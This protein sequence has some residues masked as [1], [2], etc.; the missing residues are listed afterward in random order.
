M[1]I[2]TTATIRRICD[3]IDDLKKLDMELRVNN[4]RLFTESA[5]KRKQFIDAV[6][7][8][9][10]IR[11][12]NRKLVDQVNSTKKFYQSKLSYDTEYVS[13]SPERIFIYH[14]RIHELDLD[15]DDFLEYLLSFEELSYVSAEEEY[16][17]IPKQ[18]I[19]RFES[20][21]EFIRDNQSIEMTSEDITELAPI[22]INDIY[23]PNSSFIE[24]TAVEL[25]QI[26]ETK[27]FFP[28]TSINE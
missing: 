2:S 24:M 25:H 28:V 14:A 1:L 3:K 22:N 27:K 6:I 5:A 10:A 21:L 19:E 13:L 7:T 16:N 26:E 8:S 9:N 12:F 17:V 18:T 11:N 15:P 20:C 4:V 23:A